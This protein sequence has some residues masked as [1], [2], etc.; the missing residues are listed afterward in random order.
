[1]DDID[2]KI[3]HIL[4]AH[5][6]TSATRIGEM[7]GL[8]I[9]AVNKRI[10]KL[11]KEGILQRFTILTDGRAVGKPITTYVLILLHTDIGTDDLLDYI[12]SDPDILECS[13]ITGEYD[14]L[15]KIC[16]ADVQALEQKLICLRKNGIIKSQTMLV[17]EAHKSQPT[18]LP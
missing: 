16:A 18:I 14:Y 10:Q 7:V 8:S 6:D 1:M 4:S 17:L 12:L 5:A 13:A 3:L 9:P 2:S 15:L 11:Q